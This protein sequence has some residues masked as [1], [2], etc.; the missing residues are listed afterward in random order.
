MKLIVGL[1]N[2]GPKYRDTLHN[3]GFMTM[4][5]L[6]A[7]HGV[8][9]ETAPADALMARVRGVAGGLL[10]AKPLTFMN[11]SGAAVGDLLRFFK[12]PVED[13]LVVVDEVALPAGHLRA[14]PAGSAGGHNGLKSINGVLGTEQYARLRIGVGR[15]DPRRDLAD[16]VLSAI[17]PDLRPVVDE[18]VVKAADAVECF[19]RDGIEKTMQVFNAPPPGGRDS[20]S[21]PPR[22][23]P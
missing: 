10:L 3:V 16:H 4:D 2:P 18:A 19:A 1:G 11:R 7:R 13:L 17:P 12:I 23:E 21:L 20:T 5:V 8:S 22:G 6:A 14:R 9:F 15:G